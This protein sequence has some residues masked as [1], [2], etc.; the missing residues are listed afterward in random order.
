MENTQL[1]HLI[2]EVQ[3]IATSLKDIEN[4]IHDPNGT[5]AKLATIGLQNTYLKRD[6]VS[7]VLHI[8]LYLKIARQTLDLWIQ[9]RNTAE[10]IG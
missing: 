4:R 10:K 5:F 7:M 6:A 8:N 3:E 2:D 9:A 1:A